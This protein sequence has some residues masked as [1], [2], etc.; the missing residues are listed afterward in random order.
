MSSP[1]PAIALSLLRCLSSCVAFPGLRVC[2]CVSVRRSGECVPL[3]RCPTS[4]HRS[5][6]FALLHTCARFFFLLVFVFV[7]LTFSGS[8]DFFGLRLCSRLNGP[9]PHARAHA[10]KYT[11]TQHIYVS[12]YR[13][14]AG[15]GPGKEASVKRER[16]QA[17][18]NK[19]GFSCVLVLP[20]P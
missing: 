16:K 10:H 15:G 8:L 5:L 2:V 13:T 12:T 4:F 17:K 3:L 14:R 11:Q 19:E 9:R 6:P 1:P 7:F 18:D 20:A